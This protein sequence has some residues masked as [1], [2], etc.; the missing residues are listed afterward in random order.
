VTVPNSS[1]KAA[2]S[3][4]EMASLCQLSRSRFH[5]LVRQGVFPRPVRGSEGKRPHYTQ[6]LIQRCLEI[7]STGIGQN[8]QIVLFNRPA[9]K[10]ADRK[11]PTPTPAT[12]EHGELVEALR[13]LGLTV[14]REAAGAALQSLFPAGTGGLDQ[15]D[16]IRKVFLHLQGGRK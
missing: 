2:V 15:G 9:R 14:T 11:H 10:R 12:A 6:E 3:V 7:R 13:S 4:S 16:V 1:Q 8:G 5:A